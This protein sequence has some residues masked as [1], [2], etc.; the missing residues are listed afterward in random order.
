MRRYLKYALLLLIVL[1]V[2]SVPLAMQRETA[3]L[4]GFII[5]DRGPLAQASIE[6]N[7]SV[8]RASG[9]ATS[10]PSGYYEIEGLRPGP[11]SLWAEALRHD[12]LRIPR[13][14]LQSGRRQHQDLYLAGPRAVGN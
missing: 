4:E 6:I 5:D 7:N 14:V 12:G 13:I 1:L 2:S 10:D 9:R 3:S 11:Y 8:F